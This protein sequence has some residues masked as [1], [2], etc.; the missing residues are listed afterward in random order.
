MVASTFYF[1]TLPLHVVL[2]A[3]LEFIAE[4]MGLFTLS[5]GSSAATVGEVSVSSLSATG[6]GMADLFTFG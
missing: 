6:L 1:L 5:V 4:I 3:L 2:V